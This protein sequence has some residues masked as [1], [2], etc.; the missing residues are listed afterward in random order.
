MN[1]SDETKQRL[2]QSLNSILKT[3]TAISDEKAVYDENNGVI[4]DSLEECPPEDREDLEYA[5]MNDYFDDVLDINYIIRSDK[6]YMGAMILVS[7]GGPNITINTYTG[8]IE[9]HWD[10]DDA[11]VYLPAIVV[12]DIDDLFSDWYL[13]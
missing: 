4:Y 13:M 2:E 10:S 9:V 11:K 8:C 6:T 5:T 1:M 12:S 7:Y 3:L